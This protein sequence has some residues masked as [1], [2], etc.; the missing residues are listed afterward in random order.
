MASVRRMTA[1]L[2][3]SMVVAV[4][5]VM[6]G[7]HETNA[8]SLG[9]SAVQSGVE[10]TQVDLSKAGTMS[11]IELQRA[12][13]KT[14]EHVQHLRS[15]AKMERV[16]H[17]VKLAKLR[18]RNARNRLKMKRRRREHSARLRELKRRAMATTIIGTASEAKFKRGMMRHRRIQHNWLM[19]ERRRQLEMAETRHKEKMRD[20]AEAR[21][22]R[23]ALGRLQEEQQ[24]LQHWIRMRKAQLQ[25][26]DNDTK[27]QAKKEKKQLAK[28]AGEHASRMKN[29]DAIAKGE[30]AQANKRYKNE[31]ASSIKELLKQK[32]KDAR[33]EARRERV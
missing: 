33:R 22:F 12:L 20:R 26:I 32:V 10:D 9:I 13:N 8:Q 1:A 28:E 31:I 18:L 30:E 16:Q 6:T 29:L 25:Q 21:S 24:T 17:K 2:A 4:C 7:S 5:I 14:R 11:P 27:V 15:V 3:V 23:L 19:N